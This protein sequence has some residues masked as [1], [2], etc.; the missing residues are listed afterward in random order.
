MSG[1]YWSIAVPVTFI[2]LY[3]FFLRRTYAK[4]TCI[5]E[6]PRLGTARPKDE[7]LKGTVVICG[8]S[9]AGLLTARVC[10]DHFENVIIV[11]AE[12]WAGTE[13]AKKLD[14]HQ[15]TR[16]RILQ[17]NAFQAIQ[18]F[19]FRALSRLFPTIEEECKTSGISILPA[20]FTP[21]ISGIN[22][23]A[24]YNEYRGNL[25]KVLFASRAAFEPLIRRLLLGSETSGVRQIIGTVTGVSRS[26]SNPQIL[27][28]VLVRT[29]SDNIELD[30]DLVIDCTGI[31]RAGLKWLQREGF[32]ATDTYSKGTLALDQLLIQYEHKML[33]HTFHIKV[34]PEIGRQLSIPGGFDNCGAMYTCVPTAALETR[35]IYMQRVEKDIIQV[36]AMIW[37]TNHQLPTSLEELKVYARDLRLDVPLPEWIFQVLDELEP[38]SDATTMIKTSSKP[39]TYVRYHKAV[40]LPDNFV[41][42]G[43]SVMNINPIG[44]QGI[45]KS[46]MGTIC[47]NEVLRELPSGSPAIPSSF[48]SRFFKMQAHKIESLWTGTKTRDYGF[49]TTIPLP[50][51]TLEKGKFLRWYMGRLMRLV[52]QGDKSV[53][54]SLWHA[55]Q[56]FLPSVRLQLLL[57]V[58]WDMIKH[59]K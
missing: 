27:D 10:V 28:K 16:S 22:I 17:Y 42:L 26:T 38:L 50:G 44:G 58:L 36:L 56:L 55:A 9:I 32:G 21:L 57:K 43:D 20:D 49:P 40:C 48:S 4:Y 19:A 18:V 2:T 37:G 52:H 47:L 1:L 33:Y 14:G 39:P 51:E 8:G 15:Y 11:E 24:P 41:A 12:A 13:D 46:L 45:S 35:G 30:A 25:P 31:A 7:K 54:S 3:R 53:S 59:P 5:N 29:A 6:L 23:K 34:T